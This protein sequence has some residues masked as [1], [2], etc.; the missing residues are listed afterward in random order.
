MNPMS[1]SSFSETLAQD[2]AW[3]SGIVLGRVGRIYGDQ[4]REA[5]TVFSAQIGKPA[6][7]NE[8]DLRQA[9]PTL[10][11]DTPR[12]CGAQSSHG[13]FQIDRIVR[14][15]SLLEYAVHSKVAQ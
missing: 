12:A 15:L 11:G 1:A 7:A 14:A 10:D 5:V 13:F 4:R 8:H 3:V 6:G 2:C 9:R